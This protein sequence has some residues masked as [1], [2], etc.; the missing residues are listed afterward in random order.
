MPAAKPQ[1]SSAGCL[2]HAPLRTPSPAA[3]PDL[4]RVLERYP[5]NGKLLRCYGKFLEDV[6]YAKP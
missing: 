2:Q 6:R 4:R 1:G 5:A 3:H